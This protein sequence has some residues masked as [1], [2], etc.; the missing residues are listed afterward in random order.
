[1]F[2]SCVLFQKSLTFQDIIVIIIQGIESLMTNSIDAMKVHY[3]KRDQQTSGVLARERGGRGA[4]C[5]P[6]PKK[7][8]QL[9]FFGQQEK[10]GQSQSLHLCVRILLCFEEGYFLF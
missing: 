8:E 5:R 3:Y 7:F 1:M 2:Q 4:R 6:P 9:R 10:F